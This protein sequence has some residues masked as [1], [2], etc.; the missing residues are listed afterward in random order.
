MHFKCV[1]KRHVS[2]LSYQEYT[3]ILSLPSS[4]TGIHETFTWNAT[5]M[6]YLTPARYLSNIVL[7]LRSNRFINLRPSKNISPLAS[8]SRLQ[9]ALDA[10][11]SSTIPSS[12]ATRRNTSLRFVRRE[13]RKDRRTK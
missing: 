11:R 1:N 3:I 6:L 12:L 13:G 8:Y 7:A 5:S 4:T 2:R 9:T 10:E